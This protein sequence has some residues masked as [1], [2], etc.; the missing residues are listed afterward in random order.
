[1]HVKRLSLDNTTS[2]PFF[3]FPKWSHS[4]KRWLQKKSQPLHH[5]LLVKYW[6]IPIVFK[7]IFII[8]ECLKKWF[9]VGHQWLMRTFASKNNYS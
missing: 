4:K 6:D 8:Q 9:H 3:S 7:V 2:V 5:N 1:M